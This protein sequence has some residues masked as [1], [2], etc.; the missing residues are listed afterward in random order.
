MS[1]YYDNEEEYERYADNIVGGGRDIGDN[2]GANKF[3]SATRYIIMITIITDYDYNQL[4]NSCI[5]SLG[6]ID[7]TISQFRKSVWCKHKKKD[8]FIKFKWEQYD[9]IVKRAAAA[10]R[11]FCHWTCSMSAAR[12]MTSVKGRKLHGDLSAGW[13]KILCVRPLEDV[14]FSPRESMHIRQ[15]EYQFNRQSLTNRPHGYLL[16]LTI[17]KNHTYLSGRNYC[18]PASQD[19]ITT[20]CLP[21]Q[22]L[23]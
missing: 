12:Q 15:T 14:R 2:I 3:S 20:L 22:N 6:A 11:E 17:R 18:L 10:H 16:F 8:G 7:T 13:L 23:I 4:I 1:I 5:S 19:Q 21:Q 9:T